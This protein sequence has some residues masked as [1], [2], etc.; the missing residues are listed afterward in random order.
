MNRLEIRVNNLEA[1][2]H[3]SDDELLPIFL[4]RTTLD[5]YGQEMKRDFMMYDQPPLLIPP[6]PE[7]DP[8]EPDDGPAVPYLAAY[9]D[10][11]I[12]MT[13]DQ[14]RRLFI[15]CSNKSRTLHQIP[16]SKDEQKQLD[17]LRLEINENV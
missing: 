13:N 4:V 3:V 17:A 14:F 16:F 11:P 9:R 12:F 7:R 5:Q 2:N 8:L 6:P 15:L 1:T 10:E